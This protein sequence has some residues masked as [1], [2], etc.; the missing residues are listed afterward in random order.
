[1]IK[2]R[3]KAVWLAF[4]CIFAYVIVSLVL[5]IGIV[6]ILSRDPRVLIPSIDPLRPELG[7]LPLGFTAII[8]AAAIP[9][10]GLWL[11]KSFDESHFGRRASMR[12]IIAGAVCSVFQYGLGLL[13][14]GIEYPWKA[15]IDS[16]R[17]IIALVAAYWMV[18]RL[19]RLLWKR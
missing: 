4:V 17:A 18:F 16:L 14:Q 6:Y 9:I 3:R 12:W 7:V 13:F 15:G 5:H 19:P 8:V 1:M 10:G 11:Y 2:T